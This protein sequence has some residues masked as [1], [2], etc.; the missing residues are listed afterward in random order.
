MAIV[1]LRRLGCNLWAIRENELLS[2]EIGSFGP[3]GPS[4]ASLAT[5][6]LR[7]FYSF[8]TSRLSLPRV[9]A[10]ALLKNHLS[11]TRHGV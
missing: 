7:G 3:S 2:W 1:K 9:S 8:A 10:T 4:H 11:R 5:H 6:A